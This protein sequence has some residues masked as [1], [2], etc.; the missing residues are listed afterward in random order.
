MSTSSAEYDSARVKWACRRGMLELDL[1][2]IRY[3]DQHFEALSPE[4]KQAFIQLLN[5]ADPDI[6]NWLMGYS[7]PETNILRG[8]IATIRHAHYSN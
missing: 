6:F 1:I 3:F 7:E 5:E 4:E 8:I 2:L